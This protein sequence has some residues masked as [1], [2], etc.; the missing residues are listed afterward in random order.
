MNDHEAKTEQPYPIS[1]NEAEPVP[2]TLVDKSKSHLSS[3]DSNG[4]QTSLT[5]QRRGDRHLTSTKPPLVSPKLQKKRST[6]CQNKGT[7]MIPSVEKSH[8]A[9]CHER[10]DT[11]TAARQKSKNSIDPQGLKLRGEKIGISKFSSNF[12]STGR[13]MSSTNR[14]GKNDGRNDATNARMRFKDAHSKTI[15]LSKLGLNRDI[16]APSA[17]RELETVSLSS[18]THLASKIGPSSSALINPEGILSTSNGGS[19]KKDLSDRRLKKSTFSGSKVKSS[20]T[21]PSVKSTLNIP[22]LKGQRKPSISLSLILDSLS[23]TGSSG[24]ENEEDDE[25]DDE[26]SD[27]PLRSLRK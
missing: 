8:S 26:V 6:V 18:T 13:A 21:C 1:K 16:P 5:S 27:D 23:S 4:Q 24:S 9:V 11:Q 3:A 10:I 25:S 22:P 2:L 19:A 12:N 20:N 7:L 15:F 17:N 14:E